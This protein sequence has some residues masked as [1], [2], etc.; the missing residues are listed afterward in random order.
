MSAEKNR[1]LGKG[2]EALFQ[3]FEVDV[4]QSF[5][6]MD[7][8]GRIAMIDINDIKPNKEQPRTRFD[9]DSIDELATSI[10]AHGVIQPIL[11]RS[12]DPGFEI[13][14]GERRW[15]AARKA[16][17]Q[18]IPCIVRELTEEQNMLVALIENI[19]RE[20]LNAIEEALGIRTMVQRFGLTQEQVSSS[21]G[22]SRSYVANALRLLNLP[23]KIQDMVS[24]GALSS[25]HARCIAG[26]SGEKQQID[27]ANKCLQGRWTVRQMEEYAATSPGK[28]KPESKRGVK[29]K[30][31]RDHLAMEEELKRILGTR[32]TI[33]PGVKKGTIEIEYYSREELERLLE[34]LQELK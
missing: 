5:E 19:Q 17:L 34:L 21:V 18:R 33:L 32:V 20:D 4:N 27:A 22:K 11:V 25:G 12:K 7:A 30:K 15:R 23:E 3:D 14:A 13:V 8:A 9:E 31:N 26:I 6:E 10:A 24:E 28:K 29:R 2:L 16:G 1:G